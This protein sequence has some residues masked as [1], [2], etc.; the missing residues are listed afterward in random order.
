M[1]AACD[2]TKAESWVTR[3]NI[4]SI[5]PD[6][7]TYALHDLCLEKPDGSNPIIVTVYDTC[8][9][10]DCDGCC[11]QNRGSADALIDVESYTAK[12]WGVDDGPIQWADLGPTTSDGCSGN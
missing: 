5:F 9:D 6:L 1:F 10:A 8:A 12:R 3:H 11:T 4:V 2:D 7:N